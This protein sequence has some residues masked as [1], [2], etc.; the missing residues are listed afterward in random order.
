ME[1]FDFLERIHNPADVKKVD[2][3]EL[4]TLCS[5]IR[6]KII[7]TVSETGGHLSS[8]L[9]VVELT[10]AL[11][12]AFSSPEDQIIFDV[13]HQCYTH[14]LLTGRF[15]SFDSLRQKGGISGFTNPDESE[16]DIF[17]SGH[18]SNSVSAAVG[19]ARA[20]KI[21]G[22]KGFVIA[23]IGDGSMTGGE[24]YEGLNNAYGDADNL[25]VIINDNK[26]SIAQNRGPI[27]AALSKIRSTQRYY[28]SKMK[29]EKFLGKIP[30]VGRPLRRRLV[31]YKYALKG[32]LYHSSFFEDMGFAYL[33]P[34]DGHDIAKLENIFEVAK[35]REKP[36]V[37]HVDTIKG[38]GY[39]PAQTDPERF[40]GIGKFDI[41]SGESAP[42]S[43]SFSSAFGDA[44]CSF[45]AKCLPVPV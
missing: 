3:S 20:K 39:I 13:G 22:E 35:S 44:I 10:V 23:V 36:C 28:N 29:F 27:A 41:E 34:V 32:L 16:H 21:K 7:T 40:H 4:S 42:S 33:G 12:R 19:L 26:M 2:A 14:K 11:H 8:N 6:R 45:A 18:S 24:A 1:Q 37:I 30:L 38:K 9:G 31:K 5:Q 25:I 17:F 43:K 15:D